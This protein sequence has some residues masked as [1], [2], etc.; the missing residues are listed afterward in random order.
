MKV[1]IW[2]T[3]SGI[4]DDGGKVLEGYINF[5]ITLMGPPEN[6]RMN[7]RVRHSLHAPCNIHI[8]C[9][10]WREFCFCSMPL[11]LSSRSV[12]LLLS[13]KCMVSWKVT[14]SSYCAAGNHWRH[15]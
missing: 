14:H 9:T 4:I 15:L 13:A 11:L 1:M 5:N 3:P 12:L 7:V 8:L 2:H 6:D 10:P